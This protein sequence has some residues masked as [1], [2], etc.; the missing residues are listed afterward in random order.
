MKKSNAVHVVTT[1]SLPGFKV[2]EVKGLVWA[3]TVR[4]KF[5]GKDVLASLRIVMGGEVHEYTEM[6]NEAKRYVIER[7]VQNAKTL[8]A[9]AILGT[10][11]STTA[12][13]VPGAAEITAYGTAVVV[14]KVRK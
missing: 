4:S 11:I 5:V 12:Q 14:E 13:V 3:T 2:K 7:L 9:N 6:I 8:G 10:R 1:E